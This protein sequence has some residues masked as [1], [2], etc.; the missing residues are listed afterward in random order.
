MCPKKNKCIHCTH[1]HTYTYA[2]YIP[3]ITLTGIQVV[4]AVREG[5]LEAV[6]GDRKELEFWEI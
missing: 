3:W 2:I 6:N 1:M 4:G 5:L